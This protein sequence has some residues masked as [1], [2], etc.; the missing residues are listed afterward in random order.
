MFTLL[1]SLGAVLGQEITFN[2]TFQ[3]SFW[4]EYMCVL[5]NVEV[6]DFNQTITIGGDHMEN[7]T[8]VDVEVV[9]ISNSN[10]PKM[11]PQL[12]TTFPSII[13]LE[14]VR[15]NL[16]S[17]DIPPWV[18]LEVIVLYGNNLTRITKDDFGHQRELLYLQ[19]INN[20][21]EVIDENAFEAVEKL[22][23][24]ILINNNIEQLETKTFHPLRSLRYLD[25]EGNKLTHISEQL[26]SGNPG[27]REVYLEFNRINEISPK[28]VDDIRGSLVFL[29]LRWNACVDEVFYF[30]SDSD[31]HEMRENLEI[32]FR[33][34]NETA[35][36]TRRITIEFIGNLVI[37]DEHG[38]VISRV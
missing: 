32:C 13:E 19:A 15:C 27:L 4:G 29:N 36:K 22:I 21:I 9:H 31:W 23:Y 30:K 11:F 6:L 38:N 7:R 2:C 33:N 28:F 14:M 26:L 20:N 3:L 10:T 17:I 16:V 25:L 5:S 24:L 35:P 18:Q 34:F 1:M 8:N 12:F 37:L